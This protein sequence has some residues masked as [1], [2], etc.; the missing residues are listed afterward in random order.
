MAAILTGYATKNG[1]TQLVAA[2]I[3]AA[4]TE[5]VAGHDESLRVVRG[6]GDRI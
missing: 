4:Q 3:M 1:S 5:A 2:A 6:A